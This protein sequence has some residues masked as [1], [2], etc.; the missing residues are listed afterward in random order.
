MLDNYNITKFSLCFSIGRSLLKRNQLTFEQDQSLP[1]PKGSDLFRQSRELA[2]RSLEPFYILKKRN[3]FR[4]VFQSIITQIQ[5]LPFGRISKAGDNRSKSSESSFG[6]P[7]NPR[8]KLQK[9]RIKIRR[10]VSVN[11]SHKNSIINFP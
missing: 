8:T 7:S 4:N 3:S 2:S 10:L 5:N 11:K 6:R 9:G 1:I